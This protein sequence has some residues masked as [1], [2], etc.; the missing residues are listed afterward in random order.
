MKYCRRGVN[1]CNLKAYFIIIGTNTHLTVTTLTDVVQV[2]KEILR[3]NLIFSRLNGYILIDIILV[4]IQVTNLCLMEIHWF[5]MS[6]FV[7]IMTS[8]TTIF[9]VI[10]ARNIFEFLYIGQYSVEIPLLPFI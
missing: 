5:T 8:F 6:I 3:D 10:F 4:P 9:K 1:F 2:I 7:N